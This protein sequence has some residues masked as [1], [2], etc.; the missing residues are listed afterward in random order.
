MT[1]PA[2]PDSTS[3]DHPGG[4]PPGAAAPVHAQ[5]PAPP[6]VAAPAPHKRTPART[7]GSLPDLGTVA[8]AAGLIGLFAGPILI[9]RSDARLIIL[10]ADI[11][12]LTLGAWTVWRAS[13]GF[14]QLDLG[15]AAILTGGVSLYM[16]VAYVTGPP[17][18]GGT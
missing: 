16:Y 2:S 4:E 17:P 11:V 10:V 9:A 13:R 14:A 18:P 3:A 15:I 6:P 1:E 5:P 12:A 7:R 8:V